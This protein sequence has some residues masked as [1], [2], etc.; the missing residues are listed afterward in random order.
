MRTDARWEKQQIP[1]HS[2]P[3]AAVMNLKPKGGG[4]KRKVR[5]TVTQA[6]LLV[7]SH[8]GMKLS[9]YQKGSVAAGGKCKAPAS[10]VRSRYLKMGPE[11]PLCP[12]KAYRHHL[13]PWEVG[14]QESH[15]TPDHIHHPSPKKKLAHFQS[16][17]LKKEQRPKA[18]MVR[19]FLLREQ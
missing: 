17:L 14:A 4:V 16:L 19:R 8:R 7:S 3:S 18:R 2:W 5:A 13:C 11:Q 1:Y 15:L 10:G 6:V 12:P 9:T